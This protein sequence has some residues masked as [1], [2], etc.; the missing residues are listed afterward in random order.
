MLML[1]IS[2]LIVGVIILQTMVFAPTL[3]KTNDPC[4]YFDILKHHIA[5]SP[6]GACHDHRRTNRN[7]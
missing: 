1:Y 5:L 7:P 6:Y 3:F 4:L 2:G